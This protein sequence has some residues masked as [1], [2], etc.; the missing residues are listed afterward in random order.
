MEIPILFQKFKK[1]NEEV[2]R[3]FQGLEYKHKIERVDSYG[4]LKKSR[5]IRRKNEKVVQKIEE[6]TNS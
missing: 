4:E 6:V 3:I 5:R 1:P 2:V